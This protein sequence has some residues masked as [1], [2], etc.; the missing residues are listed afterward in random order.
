[1][2][3]RHLWVCDLQPRPQAWGGAPAL[4]R[5]ALLWRPGSEVQGAPSL[6]I[7]H[8]NGLLLTHLHTHKSPFGRC[9]KERARAMLPPRAGAPPA[10]CPVSDAAFVSGTAGYCDVTVGQRSPPPPTSL[11]TY[12]DERSIGAAGEEGGCRERKQVPRRGS[13]RGRQA[14]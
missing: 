1:M 10:H 5:E 13:P 7:S 2:R 6:L 9:G 3:L 14:C 8:S 12:D 11:G 4:A